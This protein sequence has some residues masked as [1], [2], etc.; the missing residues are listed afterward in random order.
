MLYLSSIGS[1]IN[2]V[3]YSV[4]D[5]LYQP[6]NGKLSVS[7]NGY[8]VTY[9]CH[10][11]YTLSGN[12]TRQCLTNGTGWDGQDPVCGNRTITNIIPRFACLFI[13]NTLRSLWF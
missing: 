6:S 7:E 2:F 13:F 8:R 3:F 1:K 12:M 4:C 11:G 5:I 10:L 9:S